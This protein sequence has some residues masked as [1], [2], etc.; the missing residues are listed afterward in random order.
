MLGRP[1]ERVEGIHPARRSR[2]VP[3]VLT[4]REIRGIL[5][6]LAEPY[7]LCVMVM[8]GSGLRVSECATLRWKDLDLERRE[9]IVRGGKGGRDRRTPL[10]A[11]CIAPMRGRLI[12]ARHAARA[13]DRLSVRTTGLTRSLLL[14]YPVADRALSWRYVFPATRTFVDRDGVRRRHHLHVTALQRAFHAAVVNAGHEA[15]HLP[16]ATA[17]VRD[18]LAGIRH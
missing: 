14:K 18:A 17:F 1:L 13:D 4:P 16:F 5:G 2:H 8:Y 7:R 6:R 10:A 12:E 9:I 15:R 3:V 11:A